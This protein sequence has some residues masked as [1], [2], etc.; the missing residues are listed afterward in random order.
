LVLKTCAPAADGVVTFEYVIRNRKLEFVHF[1][2][3]V[4]TC[5][6]MLISPTPVAGASLP[7][8]QF[9]T[10]IVTKPGL[11]PFVFWGA[12]QPAGI[13]TTTCELFCHVAAGP[14]V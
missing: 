2:P 12:V 7:V 3:T 13:V 4:T 1:T 8:A 5:P 6:L 14:E 11:L 9:E 10:E